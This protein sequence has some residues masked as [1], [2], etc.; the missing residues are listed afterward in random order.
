MSIV[1]AATPRRSH[2]VLAA[3]AAAALAWTLVECGP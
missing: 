1:P 3:A 2:L